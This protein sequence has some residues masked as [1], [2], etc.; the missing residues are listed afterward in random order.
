MFLVDTLN[1]KIE[2]C[3][4]LIPKLKDELIDEVS[5]LDSGKAFKHKTHKD[6]NIYFLQRDKESTDDVITYRTKYKTMNRVI[7]GESYYTGYSYKNIQ[8]KKQNIL[9]VTAIFYR[10][11]SAYKSLSSGFGGRMITREA[12]GW[13]V[14]HFCMDTNRYLGFQHKSSFYGTEDKSKG[15]YSYH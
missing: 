8:L 11:Y 9:E 15:I 14:H 2:I 3:Y 6:T 5:Y 4:W 7:V 1:K 13:D 10:I 12:K